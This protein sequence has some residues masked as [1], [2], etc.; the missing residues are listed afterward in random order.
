MGLTPVIPLHGHGVREVV[1]PI[2]ALSPQTGCTHLSSHGHGGTLVWAR[3]I[4][5]VGSVS[6]PPRAL[7]NKG[8][9]SQFSFLSFPL[10]PLS[11]ET[12]SW[13][14]VPGLFLWDC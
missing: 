10:K 4:L 5:A 2:D 14:P 1:V 13:S 11:G 12:P 9:E 7:R 3:G 8:W 6:V